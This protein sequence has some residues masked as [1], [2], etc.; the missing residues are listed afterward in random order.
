MAELQDKTAN[1]GN[2]T[3]LRGASAGVYRALAAAPGRIL[4]D[5]PAQAAASWQMLLS[6]APGNNAHRDALARWRGRVDALAF[7]ARYSERRLYAGH[8]PATP[9]ALSL[10][11]M[12]EQNRVEAL[13]ARHYPG[14]WANLAALAHER[15]IRARPEVVIRGAAQ[16]W[17]ETFALL[18][19]FPLRAPMPGLDASSLASGWRGWM[20]AAQIGALDVLA[21]RLDDQAAFAEQA[22]ILIGLVLGAEPSVPSLKRAPEAA[23]EAEPRANVKAKL[24]VVSDTAPA[25]APT[26][27]T[28]APSPSISSSSA[29]DYHVYTRA[30]DQVV[31]AAQLFDEASLLRRRSEL[32][33]RLGNRTAKIARWAHRLQRKLMSLQMRSWQ[34]DCEEGELDAARLTRVVTHPLEPLA[35][36]QERA[37]RFPET[38]VTLL[39]D[40]S[41]SM[42][43]LPIATAAVCAELLGRVLERCSVKTEILGFTTRTWRGGRAHSDW[44]RA[45]R[46]QNPGRLSELRHIVYKSADETWR[47]ASPRMGAMLA[48]ELLKENVDGEALLWAHE[49]LS[50]RTEPRK[51]L[52][53]VSDGAPLDDATLEANDAAFLDRHLRS[54]IRG[55]ERQHCMELAAIGIGHDVG[56]YYS[57]SVTLRSVDDLGEAIVTQLLDLFDPKSPP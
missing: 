38:A 37:S 56:A 16:E 9:T 50:R 53:V 45:G 27:M 12:L 11:S 40:N 34:F 23:R 10:F 17:I 31:N 8:A 24:T 52:I 26:D 18:S 35:Y 25:S 20:S 15:W 3:R 22:T 39:V 32:D 42:R 48:E 14:S 5:L 28:G 43:G 19:R 47:R 46:P 49:R 57:R 36:K 2:L 29:A 21:Q 51:L 6:E 1:H 30:Y 7:R 55:I 44:S 13:G 41:G 33:G 54:V 4:H